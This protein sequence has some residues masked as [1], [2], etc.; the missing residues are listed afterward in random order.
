M[1]IKWYI[2]IA[3]MVYLTYPSLSLIFS[4]IKVTAV[5]KGMELYKRGH[6]EQIQRWMICCLTKVRIVWV[7]WPPLGEGNHFTSYEKSIQKLLC[8]IQKCAHMYSYKHK[9]NNHRS[10]IIQHN[11][12]SN[13]SE[14]KY[15]YYGNKITA[16]IVSVC[17]GR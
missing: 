15:H 1:V 7:S 12:C 16:I 6:G 10:L 5:Y 17:R 8:S 2:L 4:L 14:G 13:Y 3:N 9:W 11:S